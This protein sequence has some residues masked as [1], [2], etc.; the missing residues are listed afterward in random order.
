MWRSSGL[1]QSDKGVR[2]GVF[3]RCGVT[4]M[5]VEV[6]LEVGGFHVVRGI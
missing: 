1:L 2:Y 5:V 4:A 6:L 3:G